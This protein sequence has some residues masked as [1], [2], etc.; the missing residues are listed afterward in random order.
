[1]ATDLWFCTC[2]GYRR[3]DLLRIHF[4]SGIAGEYVRA[5][6]VLEKKNTHLS[7]RIVPDSLIQLVVLSG[8]TYPMT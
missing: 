8:A 5:V 7:V 2:L 1:M 3:E 6:S 4:N